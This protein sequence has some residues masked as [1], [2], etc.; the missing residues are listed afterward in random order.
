MSVPQ[1]HT[2]FAKAEAQVCLTC[3]ARYGRCTH[4]SDMVPARAMSDMTFAQAS[5]WTE[6]EDSL[7]IEMYWLDGIS[8]KT[9]A[10][11]L[12]RSIAAVDS[13]IHHI[14]QTR[15]EGVFS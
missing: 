7:L 13:R 5:R 4:T 11:R 12:S 9:I 6:G 15:R 8:A 3:G 1:T 10:Q 14:K 2:A